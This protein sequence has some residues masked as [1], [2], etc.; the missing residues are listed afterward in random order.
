MSTGVVAKLCGFTSWIRARMGSP[1]TGSRVLDAPCRGGPARTAD[2][3]EISGRRCVV[4]LDGDK[5]RLAG[6]DRRTVP[7][8]IHCCGRGCSAWVARTLC[9]GKWFVLWDAA[10]LCIV[11]PHSSTWQSLRSSESISGARGHAFR[12]SI[13]LTYRAGR[14]SMAEAATCRTDASAVPGAMGC[15]SVSMHGGASVVARVNQRG[16]GGRRA[17]VSVAPARTRTRELM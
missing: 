11:A 7:F 13:A 6:G 9:A 5:V 1:T 12:L 15:V 14:S 2:G 3:G 17:S 10:V 4:R 8:L 16:V